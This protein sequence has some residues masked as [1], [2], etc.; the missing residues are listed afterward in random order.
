MNKLLLT[1]ALAATCCVG[2]RADGLW[3][4][5]DEANWYSGAKLTEESLANKVVMVYSLDGVDEMA[6]RIE[7]LWNSFKTKPFVIVAT[8][9]GGRNEAAVKA[10][11]EKYKLTMPVYEGFDYAFDPPSR[12]LYVVS[13]RGILAWSGSE[14]REATDAFVTAIG[15]VGQPPDILRGAMLSAKKRKALKNKIALG[16]PLKSEIAKLEKTIKE[17]EKIKKPNKKKIDQ[18]EEAKS[19]LEAISSGKDRVKQEIEALKKVNPAEAA[20]LEKDY[21]VSF[22]EEKAK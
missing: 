7:Q 10:I 18:C 13:H 20:K 6:S 14:D 16:K 2:A 17:F 8:H 21:F 15:D 1:A 9:H 12:A 4:G 22:P 5:L 19:I 3:K 11:V